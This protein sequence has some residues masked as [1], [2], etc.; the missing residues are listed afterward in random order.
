MVK[1]SSLTRWNGRVIRKQHCGLK[2][3]KWV[4]SKV[5]RFFLMQHTKTGKRYQMVIKVPNGR[6][7]DQKGIKYTIIFHFKTLQNI[8]KLGFLVLKYIVWQH[9]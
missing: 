6:K 9:W 5:A 4:K 7:I 1:K 2:N 8:P 3:N